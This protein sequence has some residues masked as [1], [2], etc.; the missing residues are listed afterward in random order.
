[1]GADLHIGVETS[2]IESPLGTPGVVREAAV[3]SDS[4][5]R[6]S[7]RIRFCLSGVSATNKSGSEAYE[8]SNFASTRFGDS[9][10]RHPRTTATIKRLSRVR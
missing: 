6:N 8:L 3:R 7:A 1:M 9:S 5:G 2:A 10:P 4:I